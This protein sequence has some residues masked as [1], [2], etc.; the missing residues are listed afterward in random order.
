MAIHNPEIPFSSEGVWDEPFDPTAFTDGT[1][2]VALNEYGVI[3]QMPE[4]ISRYKIDYVHRV[5]LKDPEVTDTGA[6]IYQEL[7]TF[8]DSNNDMVVREATIAV[9]NSNLV[10]TVPHA[11][12]SSDPWITGPSGLNRIKTRELVDMG[13]PVVWLHHAD[14]RSP[15]RRNKSISRSARQAHALLDDLSGSAD[16]SVMDVIADGYSRGGMTGEKFIGLASSHDRKVLFSIFD[17]PCFAT[18]MTLAEKR[19]AIIKQLPKEIKG[20]GSLAIGHFMH[21][22][23]HGDLGS[24]P[25]FAKTL[26][27]H[28]KN[29]AQEVMWAKALVNANVGS[30]ITYQ[31]RDTAGIRNF[32]EADT[33]SQQAEYVKLYAPLKNVVVVGHDGAHIEGASPNYLYKVRRA[34]FSQLGRAILNGEVLDAE[35]IAQRAELDLRKL[36]LVK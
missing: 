21:G 5:S 33:M 6:H 7:C 2:A 23:K 36:T 14:Q 17:A 27:I 8:Y 24:L 3:P 4:Y 13:F 28:P 1:G 20:I 22:L 26:N 12:I 15:L 10:K 16:F 19:A 30:M 32:F 25:E 11:L 18:D 29:V 35:V 34:Q 9:P 31:P